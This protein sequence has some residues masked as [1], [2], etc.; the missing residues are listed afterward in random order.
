MDKA[1]KEILDNI[2]TED[3]DTNE[4]QQEN[5]QYDHN[6][7]SDSRRH[8]TSAFLD[9]FW[10]AAGKDEAVGAKDHH[11]EGSATG[12]AYTK[13]QKRFG[14]PFGSRSY[15]SKGGYDLVF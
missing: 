5:S 14:Q 15:G 4:I 8:H 10:V 3:A 9:R 11:Q 2:Q 12:R 7:A 1:L 6:K 13:T